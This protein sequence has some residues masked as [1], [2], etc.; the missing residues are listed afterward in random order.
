MKRK[1]AIKTGKMKSDLDFESLDHSMKLDSLKNI[2]F[3]DLVGPAVIPDMPLPLRMNEEPVH[4]G[5][6]KLSTKEVKEQEVQ[7]AEL[8]AKKE[9]ERKAKED[10]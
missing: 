2:G 9:E 7:K 4:I 3:E 5:P 10:L 6:R 1:R 8:E